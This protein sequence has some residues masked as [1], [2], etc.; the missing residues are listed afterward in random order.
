VSAEWER[1]MNNYQRHLALAHE[2]LDRIKAGSCDPRDLA[3]ALGGSVT[4]EAM[5]NQMHRKKYA[6][7]SNFT[8]EATALTYDATESFRSK[9]YQPP[10][11]NEPQYEVLD[12]LSSPA[13]SD[14]EGDALRALE[15]ASSS[16]GTLE[17]EVGW[18]GSCVTILDAFIDTVGAT[19][20]ASYAG[21]KVGFDSEGKLTPVGRELDAVVASS[22][23]AQ[24]KAIAKCFLRPPPRAAAPVAVPAPAVE[25]S[26]WKRTFGDS[27]GLGM[28]IDMHENNVRALT[29]MLNHEFGLFT[30]SMADPDAGTRDDCNA[31][32]ESL[33]HQAQLV[34]SL[35]AELH[36]S[37]MTQEEVDR[38]DGG[39]RLEHLKQVFRKKCP[40]PRGKR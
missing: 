3:L 22:R 35:R 28:P 10:P 27:S 24:D 31:M 11:T 12:G 26:W 33:H 4:A 17:R 18:G 29:E 32:F 37:G 8:T 23:K 19:A 1:L 34:G 39:Q 15:R 38:G 30:R 20:V 21:Q 40:I 9:C 2:G 36:G 5:A 6:G 25:K 16:A 7:A 13:S 14:P